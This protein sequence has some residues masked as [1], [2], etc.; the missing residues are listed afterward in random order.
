VTIGI[1]AGAAAELVAA[2]G[3]WKVSRGMLLLPE[4]LER[5]VTLVLEVVLLHRSL[6]RPLI[7]PKHR[8]GL[9]EPLLMGLWEAQEGLA[10]LP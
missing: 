2:L 10:L 3:S 5:A 8:V 9:G 7:H 4:G 6:H 1:T